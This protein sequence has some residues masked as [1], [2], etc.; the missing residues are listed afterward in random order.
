MPNGDFSRVDGEPD[1]TEFQS[2]DG[3]Q[4]NNGSS[5][6]SLT[7]WWCESTAHSTERVFHISDCIFLS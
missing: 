6:D 3:P 5:Y 1:D 4:L 7:L 2:A